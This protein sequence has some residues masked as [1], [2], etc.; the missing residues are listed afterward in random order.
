MQLSHLSHK[1]LDFIYG[2]ERSKKVF[3][4]SNM[5]KFLKKIKN[6]EK[7][8][9]VI[10]IA[11]TNGKGS[12]C[13]MIS[14]TLE[15]AGYS[16]GM[17][18]SP[19]LIK[20]N[21]RIQINN[22]PIPN[23]DMDRLAEMM[24]RLMKKH[25]I[26]LTFFETLTVIAFLYFKENNVDYAVLE[27]GMGGRL[28]ATNVVTPIVS[29][30]TNIGKDHRDVLGRTI[31]EISFEK[32]GIIKKGVP[33]ITNAKGTASKIIK[34]T[35]NKNKS[36][37]IKIKKMPEEMKIGLPG[38]YQIENASTAYTTLKFLNIEEKDIK[39][40]MKKAYW[41][42]RFE[43]IGKNILLDC[44]HNPDGIRALVESIGEVK[45]DNMIVILGMMGDKDAKSMSDELKKLSKNV[46][47]TKINM[48]K[49]I[50]PEDLAKYFP[51]SIIT[52]DLEHALAFARKFAKKKDLIL[53][54]G[55][56]YLAG[57][58]L[59]LLRKH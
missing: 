57:E 55:S 58:A 13:E 12:V 3:N 14:S 56:V 4:L 43:K 26:Y 15:Q 50:E 5:K 40:G 37:L 24:K 30:I 54:T 31:K 16:V 46:I 52:H 29:V 20:I 41:P 27:T 34:K 59:S 53:I 49:S 23:R 51:I 35:A 48:T 19:H 9:K 28:D 2:I 39:A 45:Y 11:G 10:H 22:I 44:A 17:Y 21:E 7:S 25:K 18:T 38:K 47:L 42:G 33:V 8:L 36:E 1:S 32:A 6:P